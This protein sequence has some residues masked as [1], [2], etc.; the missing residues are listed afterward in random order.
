MDWQ[1]LKQIGRKVYQLRD[2][3]DYK[4]YYVFLARCKLN[5]KL[6]NEHLNFFL[7]DPQRKKALLGTPWLYDQVTRQV[8]Y[9]DSNFEERASLVQKHLLYLEQNFK[10]EFSEEIYEKGRR[11]LLWEDS[12]EDKPLNLYMVFRDG[13]QKEGCISIELIY[14]STDLEHTD[15]AY[16]THVYQ[17]M[18]LFGDGKRT[19]NALDQEHLQIN[20]GA[21]Q[22]LAGGN[23]FIKKLTKHYFGYRPKNLI[24]YSL[25]C[26]AEFL[27]AKKIIAVSNS[28][29]YAMNHLRMNRKLKVD[30]NN[31]W[32]ECNGQELA[33]KRFFEIPVEEYRKDMSEL[34]PSKRAQH[35]RRFEKMDDIKAQIE[36]NLGLWMK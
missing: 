17:I 16:G 33:D 25:R 9:K 4:R 8:F 30:L 5:E 29:Y 34:K 7:S 3:K 15:W 13:Q 35:R 6:A 28:G 22:G 32:E 27:N 21:L 14:D 2:W 11:I 36:K 20:I 18:F 10:P 19:G 26:M 23:E 1:L 12:F 24:M 31:F